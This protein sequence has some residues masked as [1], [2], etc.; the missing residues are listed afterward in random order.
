M[1]TFCEFISY[2]FHLRTK[3]LLFLY[4]HDITGLIGQ[5][6][7]ML[8]SICYPLRVEF[9]RTIKMERGSKIPLFSIQKPL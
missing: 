6:Q 9:G 5:I 1:E 3:D 2:T 8:Y 4:Q 7:A